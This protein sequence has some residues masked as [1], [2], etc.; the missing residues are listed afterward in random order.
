MVSVFVFRLRNS[1]WVWIFNLLAFPLFLTTA[2]GHGPCLTLLMPLTF[3]FLFTLSCTVY[4][5]SI[6]PLSWEYYLQHIALTTNLPL[7]SYSQLISLGFDLAHFGPLL[8]PSSCLKNTTIELSSCISYMKRDSPSYWEGSRCLWPHLQKSMNHYDIC[9][10]VVVVN[11]QS[12]LINHKTTQLFGKTILP[13]LNLYLYS[14]QSSSG[15]PEG[16]F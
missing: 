15:D 6:L 2:W 4:L 11:M 5:S 13:V 3:W 10:K 12:T 8:P 1:F 9:T 7:S 16:F 14:H